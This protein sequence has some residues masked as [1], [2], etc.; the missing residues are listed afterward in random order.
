MYLVETITLLTKAMR[1]AFD[2]DLPDV[3]F[4]GIPIGIEY[5]VDKQSYPSIW[6]DFQPIGPLV[7]VSI[8]HVE[9]VDAVGGGKQTV[10]RWSFGGVVNYTAVAF[11]NLERF[12]L[13]DAL[14]SVIAFRDQDPNYGAF[15]DTIE[16]DPLVSLGLNY[17]Q[18]NQPGFSAA[19]GT[20][21]GSEE[22]M[23]E[24]TISLPVIGEFVSSPG[25]SILL[26]ISQVGVVTWTDQVEED[27]TTDG[28][29]M[30]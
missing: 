22:M 23:Y 13:V 3:D 12:R 2:N 17:H 26:D 5:P 28:G 29:W 27:P 4:R 7:P 8:G 11:T 25:T 16:S 6:V 18:I 20:P 14:V 19:P 1:E 21:W 30:Q 9:T 10:Q 15:R 24:G